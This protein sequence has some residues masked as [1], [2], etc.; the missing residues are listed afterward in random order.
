MLVMYQVHF[1]Y[2][3]GLGVHV[4]EVLVIY[5]VSVFFVKGPCW[6]CTRLVLVIYQ[7]DVGYVPG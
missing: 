7:V 1:G 6:L 5:Q 3:G 2:V 4:G